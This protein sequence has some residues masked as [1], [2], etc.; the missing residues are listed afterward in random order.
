MCGITALIGKPCAIELYNSLEQLQNRGYDSAGIC[1]V[2]DN[3]LDYQK[4]ASTSI[5]ALEKIKQQLFNLENSNIGI[6]HTRWATHGPKTDYNAH[7]H[8]SYDNKFALVH[9][10]IIEN[11]K[12][13]K[14][15]LLNE[16]IIFN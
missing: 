5:S 6:A 13:L 4:Y 12:T 7:P 3:K 14:N 11:Y 9:N 2:K 15:K 1:V 10:G 16:R 8:I